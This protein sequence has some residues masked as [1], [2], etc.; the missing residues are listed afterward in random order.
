[1]VTV[2]EVAPEK[3][4]PMVAEK[5]KKDVKVPEWANF[6][7]TGAYATN[8]PN[9]DNWW[10]IR[11][12]SVLRKVYTDGPVG[13]N[14]LRVWYGGRKNRGVRPE[15]SVKAGG[16]IIRV[17]LQNL[18]ELKYVKKTKAGR[19]ITPEGRKFIDSIAFEVQKSG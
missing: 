17:I 5:L 11:T 9:Q 14:R 12:A 13:V 7:K 19:E 4:I 15:K 10:C 2:F 16:K 3:L 1:M 8:I 6:V 18:E